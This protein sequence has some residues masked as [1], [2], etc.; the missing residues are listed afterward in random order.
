MVN[1]NFSTLNLFKLR[2]SDASAV[3]AEEELHLEHLLFSRS[4]SGDVAMQSGVFLKIATTILS[5]VDDILI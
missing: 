2:N 3:F 5:F 1:R 4:I